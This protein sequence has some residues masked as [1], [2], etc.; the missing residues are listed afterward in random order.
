M[1]AAETLSD[2][3]AA[4]TRAHDQ[5]WGL[6]NAPG[7]DS[8][9]MLWRTAASRHHRTVQVPRSDF[10]ASAFRSVLYALA[11][12]SSWAATSLPTISQQLHTRARTT[13]RGV[14]PAKGRH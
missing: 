10:S 5:L 13:A 3:I 8:G 7:T 9:I 2:A 14:H 11:V 6:R 4:A 12:R 1:E